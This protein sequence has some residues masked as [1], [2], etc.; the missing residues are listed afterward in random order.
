MAILF[1]QI[2]L[3]LRLF[4]AIQNAA[5]SYACF[6]SPCTG[7]FHLCTLNIFLG[8]VEYIFGCYHR[9]LNT[10]EFACAFPLAASF[11]QT[12]R[13]YSTQEKLSVAA[14]DFDGSFE[15]FRSQKNLRNSN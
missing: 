15:S 4:E 3:N 12:G 13:V 5:A 14:L 10:D 2:L 11:F 9:V 1:P 6:H 7:C 8:H